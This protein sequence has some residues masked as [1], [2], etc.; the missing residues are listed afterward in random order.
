MAKIAD[1]LRPDRQKWP[2]AT[3]PCF[4]GKKYLKTKQW[5]GKKRAAEAAQLMKIP[6]LLIWT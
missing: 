5:V 1:I 2:I 4:R 3:N 6:L